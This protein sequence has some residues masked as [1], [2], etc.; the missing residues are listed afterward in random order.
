MRVA[1]FVLAVAAFTFFTMAE[2]ASA[3][4]K[5]VTETAL[6]CTQERAACARACA[7]SP[8]NAITTR[9]TCVTKCNTAKLRCDK[10]V[11]NADRVSSIRKAH[12]IKTRAVI[13]KKVH[14]SAK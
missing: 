2:G 8:L 6:R 3:D 13:S 9:A 4:P 14:T 12:A 7:G 11:V 5:P 10:A 1:F